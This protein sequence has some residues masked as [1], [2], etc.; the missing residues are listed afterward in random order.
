LLSMECT[1]QM[2][3][4]LYLVSDGPEFLKIG[5][6]KME[7]HLAQHIGYALMLDFFQRRLVRTF[8]ING[9]V[10]WISWRS[11]KR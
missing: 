5:K 4:S 3:P 9:I 10:K 1:P 6:S 2:M 8:F 7:R 11:Q